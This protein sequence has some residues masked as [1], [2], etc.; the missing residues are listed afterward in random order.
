MLQLKKTTRFFCSFILFYGLL[1]A[2]WPGLGA[3]YSKFFRSSAA[4]L[5]DPFGSKCSVHFKKSNHPHGDILVVFYD[6]SKESPSGDKRPIKEFCIS[7]RDSAYIYTAFLF[8]LILATPITLKRK[9]WSLFWGMILLHFFLTIKMAVLILHV[10]THAPSAPI[11][12]DPFWKKVLF[13]AQQGFL[14][15]MVF[16]FIVSVF[17]WFLV[18]F[19]LWAENEIFYNGLSGNFQKHYE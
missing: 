11:V 17:I 15:H 4:F 14:Q 3:A 7:S 18:T 1:M 19:R 9:G 5:F 12:L 13:F 2:P 10:F 16:C 6:L 8:A